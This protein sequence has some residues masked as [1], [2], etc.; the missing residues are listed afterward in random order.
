MENPWP[1]SG[2]GFLWPSLTEEEVRGPQL[3]SICC[4]SEPRKCLG[5]V[6]VRCGARREGWLCQEPL[7]PPP[8]LIPMPLRTYAGGLHT[9]WFLCTLCV[10]HCPGGGTHCPQAV[11][12]E[13]E[14]VQEPSSVGWGPREGAAV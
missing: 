12:V 13:L 6:P 10:P 3:L 2:S 5:S 7:P 8:T 11:P 14:L 4:P 9:P 1:D